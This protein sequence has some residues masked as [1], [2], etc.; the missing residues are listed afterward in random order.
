MATK[1]ELAGPSTAN[2]FKTFFLV[3]ALYDL[4]LGV[5]FFFFFGPIF[6][7]LSVPLPNNTSYIQLTAGFIFTQGVS[8]WF[9][10]RNMVRNTDLVKVGAMYKAIYTLVAAYYWAIGQ[11]PHA[12]FAWFAVFD[13]LFL[14]GFL[15]FLM[16]AQPAGVEARP[17]A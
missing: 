3:A 11:L 14:L 8:Y 9:V 4:I 13:V 7:R 17:Q 15:R 5:V 2:V 6:Q 1:L 12:V 16:L 10:Y